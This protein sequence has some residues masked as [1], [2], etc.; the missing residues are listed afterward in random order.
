MKAVGPRRTLPALLMALFAAFP[1]G[2]AW[3]AAKAPAHAAKTASKKYQGPV[4]DMRWGPVQVT[5][6]VKGKK[7]TNVTATAPNERPRSAVINDQALPLLKSE[8]LQAQS[9]AID[10]V[11]GAT[12]TSEAFITSLQAALKKAHFKTS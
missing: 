12:M 8:V 4:E 1:V 3:A 11:A 9:A 6:S 10:E 2:S 7:I 5:V